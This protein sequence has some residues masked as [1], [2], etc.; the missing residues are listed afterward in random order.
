MLPCDCLVIDHGWHQNVVK[1][2][3]WHTRRSRVCGWCSYHILTSSLIYYWTDAR[4]HKIYLF[5]IITKSLFFI[6]K[7]ISAWRE[8][9]PLPRLCPLWRRRKKKDIWRNLWSIQNEAIS[10]VTVRSKELWLVEEN[11]ATVKPDSSVATRGMK[12][13]FNVTAKFKSPE[14]NAGKIKSVSVIRAALWT[15]KLGRRL[16]NCRSWK[17]TVRKIVVP[18]NLEAIWFE[19]WVKGLA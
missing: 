19:F 1:T 9:R 18:I 7:Y 15:E 10:L 8:S 17:N 16:E 12:A 3:K 4:Q 2:K 13:E 11:H 5:Y 14:E 6:S